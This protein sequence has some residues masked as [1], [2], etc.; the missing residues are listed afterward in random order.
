[1]IRKLIGGVNL[2]YINTLQD[3]VD[4][5]QQGNNFPISTAKYLK[6]FF[7][8]LQRL[9]IQSESDRPF[10]LCDHG[11][12]LLLLQQKESTPA[13]QAVGLRTPGSNPEYVERIVLEDCQLFKACL[14]EDN[15]AF[16]FLISVV[17]TQMEELE[18]WFAAHAEGD[19][20]HE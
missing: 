6:D 8:D 2:I 7:N 16:T 15:E 3:T 20:P 13:L 14:M 4:A 5:C 18:N 11:Y 12:K 19:I 1:M 10:H 17:G 9:L